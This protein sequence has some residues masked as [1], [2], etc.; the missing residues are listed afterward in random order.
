[1]GLKLYF[2]A[3]CT[4]EVTA[5]NPDT[6]HK[7]VVS[8]ADMT[9]ERSLWIKSDDLALTYENIALTSQGDD[10]QV[11][12]K[13]AAD[14]NGSPGVY[15][16]SLS[17]PNGDFAAAVRVWRKVTAPSVTAAFKRTNINHALTWDEYVV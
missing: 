8:G 2:D 13:Y 12:V 16:D 17:L 15:A 7:A 1:M 6:V 11:D 3:E 5:T 4:Q 14:N 9:D 10:A